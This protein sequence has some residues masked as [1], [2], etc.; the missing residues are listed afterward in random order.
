MK[1]APEQTPINGDKH[2][3]GKL[4]RHEFNQWLCK[5]NTTLNAKK[6]PSDA[7]IYKKQ[8]STREKRWGSANHK[9][10]LINFKS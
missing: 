2:T 10:P 4:Q 8:C 1:Y 6:Q 9:Q 5:T 3:R 7:G